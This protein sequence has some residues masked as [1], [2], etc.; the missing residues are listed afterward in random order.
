MGTLTGKTALVT[1]ASRGIGQGIALR[2][3]ADGAR[4]AVHYNAN[5]DAAKQTVAT[6]EAAGAEA[7]AIQAELG[8]PGDA[9][10]LWAA[11]DARAEGVDIIVNN[12]AVPG[13]YG[14]LGAI[15][16]DE[17]DKVFA[18]NAKAPFFVT[19]EGLTRLRDGGRVINIS[20]GLTRTAAMSELI[21]YAMSKGAIDVFTVNLAK[22]LGTRGITVNTIAPGVVDTDVN[23]TWLRGNDQALAAT[24][25]L[26]PLNRVADPAEIADIA[27]FLASDDSRWVTG[28]WIDATGG[29]LII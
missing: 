26:S 7:F 4:V 24:A 28:Q 12:A 10:T 18:V 22:D 9:R 27:A 19:Q 14:H 20:T 23:A 21:A 25:A 1:G 29:A 5:E 11:F 17:F 16:P 13:P 6:I 2:L 8:I 3:A 15:D